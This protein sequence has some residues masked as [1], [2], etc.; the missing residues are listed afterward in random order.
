M[1]RLQL[2]LLFIALIVSPAPAS[3]DKEKYL[4]ENRLLEEELTL[5]RKPDIY[6]AFNLK[7]KM[8]YIKVR[9]IHLRELQINDFHCWGSPV[10]DNVYRLRKKSTFLKPGRE[11]IKPGESKKKDHFEIEALELADMPSR[12]TLVFDGGMKIWVRPSTEGI[13][14]GIGNIFYPSMRFFIRPI[15]ML[16]Y[17]LR[18][19][20]YTAID[21]VLDKNDARAVY[22][23][24]SEGSG[25]IIYSPP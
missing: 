5:A 9:G 12:Y 20:P 4:R 13:A 3:N 6:F 7:E 2:I 18:G 1:M 15:L 10:S 11:M 21:M 22:W 8:V 16:W 17:T 14:S 23:S 19:K 25:A 24:L